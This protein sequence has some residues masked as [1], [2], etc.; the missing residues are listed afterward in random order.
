M[1]EPIFVKISTYRLNV[2]CITD[3]CTNDKYLS[4]NLSSGQEINIKDPSGK[5]FYELD[6]VMSKFMVDN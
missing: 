2:R 5:L 1:S 4:I 6:E 3:Y